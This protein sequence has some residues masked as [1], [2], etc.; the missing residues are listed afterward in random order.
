MI[1]NEEFL[2]E[3]GDNHF[4]SNAKNP[5]REDAFALTDEEKI[6]K[7]M[8]RVEANDAGATCQLGNFYYNGQL[9]LQQN[10]ENKDDD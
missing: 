3:I 10:K 8:N 2:D 4:S 9:G 6:E 5:L 1:N 7:L